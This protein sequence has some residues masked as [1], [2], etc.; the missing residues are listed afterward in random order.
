MESDNERTSFIDGAVDD[1]RFFQTNCVR[2]GENYE[3]YGGAVNP[4]IAAAS[5]F[6]FPSYDE[7]EAFYE[8][9][10][11]RYIYSRV[12]NPTVR[13]L[14]EKLALLERA[15]AARCFASGMAAIAAAVMSRVRSGDRVV[16]VTNL[17]GVAYKL[18]TTYLSKFDIGVDFVRGDSTEEIAAL[19]RPETRI[20]YLESPS[21]LRF[22]L[23]DLS[24]VAALAKERGI[25]TIIDNSLATPYNQ[26]PIDYGID[27]VVHSLSKY[28]NGHS[29]VIGGVVIGSEDRLRQLA[30]T[31]RE[32]L[33]APLSPFAAWLT[34]R[35][36]R[37]LGIRL[38][39][40]QAS[41]MQVAEFLESHP[42]VRRVYY[43]GLASFPQRALAR[44]QMR[45][46]SGLL[47]FEVDTAPDK[48]PLMFNRLRYISIGVSWG[49]YESIISQPTHGID[50]AVSSA[51]RAEWGLSDNLL[52]LSVGLE[53][54]EVLIADL[55]QALAGL[56]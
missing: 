36:L 56:E 30:S 18:L 40:H 41:A 38:D 32:L 48:I 54:A 46:Y 13:V 14:E 45:G 9:N 8:G 2:S 42:R 10:S 20:I 16:A 29:D 15:E 43:P 52:R 22:T 5:L 33:G 47:S 53:D 44:R 39:R 55:E 1:R 49:G 23:Q 28:I 4:P 24:A 7:M 17:Y 3:T 35:G 6:T 26:N 34:L 27:L 11:E 31:E 50:H 25:T 19:L 37:T 21:S 12:S 51:V